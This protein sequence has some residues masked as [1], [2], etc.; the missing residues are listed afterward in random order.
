MQLTL[1]L[2]GFVASLLLTLAAY[3][4]I[5]HAEWFDMG[6]RAATIAIFIL[7]GI[8]SVVQLICFIDIWQEKGPLWNFYVFVSTL[9][10]IFI[11]IFFSIWIMSHLNHNMMPHASGDFLEP[12]TKESSM[13]D[14]FSYDGSE[15]T[16]N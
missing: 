1:R 8:Q 2:T 14:S 5:L 7:A 16:F 11:V 13:A 9:S 12:A 4:L 3:F 15:Q 10:I 6:N